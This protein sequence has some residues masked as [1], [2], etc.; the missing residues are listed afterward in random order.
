M[1]GSMPLQYQKILHIC[2]LPVGV[3]H[4]LDGIHHLSQEARATIVAPA[5][6]FD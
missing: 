6:S 5:A 2:P 4:L 1:A 3:Y